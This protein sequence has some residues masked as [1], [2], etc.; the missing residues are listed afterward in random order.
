MVGKIIESLKKYYGGRFNIVFRRIFDQSPAG[1]IER[2][3]GW[4]PRKRLIIINPYKLRGNPL[5]IVDTLA[6]ELVHALCTAPELRNA[7]LPR[8]ATDLANDPNIPKKS[9]K[10]LI[11]G[12]FGQE[13][14][15][16]QKFHN[17]MK[18][19]YGKSHSSPDN[20]YIDINI[21]AQRWVKKICERTQYFVY[22]H[23]A[24]DAKRTMTMKS[25]IF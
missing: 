21:P 10:D 7:F 9:V 11:Q 15:F 23:L 2:F 14:D 22:P 17:Y 1:D 19:N 25:S 5:E 18:T 20:E 8:S 16:E 24:P 12:Y 6:H 13:T 4:Y 3:G